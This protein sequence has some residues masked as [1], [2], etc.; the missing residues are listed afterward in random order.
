MGDVNPHVEEF[1][2]KLRRRCVHSHFETST[3]ST[4][5]HR[6]SSFVSRT[7]PAKELTTNF[8]LARFLLLSR[9]THDRMLVTRG[10]TTLLD[11]YIFELT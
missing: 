3:C 11:S 8:L 5:L 4:S 1:V 10:Q 7:T 6:R 9:V 2:T